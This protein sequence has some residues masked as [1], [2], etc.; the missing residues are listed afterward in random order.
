[1]VTARFFTFT[2]YC[3]H[4]ALLTVYKKYYFIEFFDC[5]VNTGCMVILHSLFNG[6]DD[7]WMKFCI[8]KQQRCNITQL[9]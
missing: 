5:T 7:R 4:V 3:D 6:M 2:I 8:K 9:L 1:M